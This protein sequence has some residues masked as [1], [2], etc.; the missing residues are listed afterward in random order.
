[1]R[2]EFNPFTAIEKYTDKKH[3]TIIQKQETKR[4]TRIWKA[5]IKMREIF[6]Q[7]I[8]SKVNR[9]NSN[10]NQRQDEGIK[11]KDPAVC[12]LQDITVRAKSP[13]KVEG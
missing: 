7:A 11:A 6:F 8:T 10:Q 2:K 13:N 12:C 4:Q 1:M 3:K 9:F 5:N